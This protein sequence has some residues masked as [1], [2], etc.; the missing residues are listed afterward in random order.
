MKIDGDQVVLISRVQ[1]FFNNRKS[2]IVINDINRVK[3]K[4][5]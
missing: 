2:F 4:I 1:S 5:T 3:K